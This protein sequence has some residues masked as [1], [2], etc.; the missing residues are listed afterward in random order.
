[1]T[2]VRSILTTIESTFAIRKTI[3]SRTIEAPVAIENVEVAI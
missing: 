3:E 2:K 1:M